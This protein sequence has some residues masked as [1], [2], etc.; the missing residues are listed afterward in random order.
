MYSFFSQG[1]YD[2]PVNSALV[3]VAEIARLAHAE[4]VSHSV[5]VPAL[6]SLDVAAEP[7]VAISTEV[8]RVVPPVRMLTFCD[9][10]RQLFLGGGWRYRALSLV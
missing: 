1:A 6:G 3:I 2:L 10:H 9:W 5:L 4:R 8:L 7:T